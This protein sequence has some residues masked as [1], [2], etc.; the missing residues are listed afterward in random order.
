M[1]LLDKAFELI[2]VKL[3]K[4]YAEHGVET[5]LDRA[6]QNMEEEYKESYRFGFAVVDKN[7][8][9]LSNAFYLGHPE[10]KA[11][12][13]SNDII[14]LLVEYGA[15]DSKYY[16][17]EVFKYGSKELIEL[18]LAKGDFE[19]SEKQAKAILDSALERSVKNPQE[20][21]EILKLALNIV[22]YKE[23]K[24]E[25]LEKS[26]CLS[27]D[28][29]K[30]KILLKYGVNINTQSCNYGYTK[31]METLRLVSYRGKRSLELAIYLLEQGA[32]VN[33]VNN[34]GQSALDIFRELIEWRY[35][36]NKQ[37][38][39][40]VQKIKELLQEKGAKSGVEL[41]KTLPPKENNKGLKE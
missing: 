1:I 8:Q 17:P 18:F 20:F 29:D 4:M 26:F 14:K 16:L 37:E 7:N 24:Q 11:D 9:A 36:S 21:D 10:F 13:K 30:L 27:D 12:F 28:V 2:F 3:F 6:M 40:Q 31:L 35:F 5:P 39:N 23:L 38:Q 34:Q 41:Q 25:R 32:D 15:D 33:R 19:K 22:P